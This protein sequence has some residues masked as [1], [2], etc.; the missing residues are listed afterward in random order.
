MQAACDLAQWFG[1]EAIRIYATL[2]ETSDQRDRRR[3]VEFIE[4]RNGSVTV[5]EVTQSFR[6]LKNQR[7]KTEA[8]LNKLVST[9]HGNW[10][11]VGTTDKGGRPTRKFQLLPLS[12]STKPSHLRGK[13]GG[14]VDTPN[15]V[16]I[17]PD[18]EQD[19]D[20]VSDAVEDDGPD[21]SWAYD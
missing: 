8:A 14:I 5:R 4:S 17:T 19:F 3:L 20:A 15:I 18:G 9:G 1:D 7:D 12:T 13:T 16:K 21:E 2:T 6:P 10:G 11:P